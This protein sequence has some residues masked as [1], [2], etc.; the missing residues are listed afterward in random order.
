MNSAPL[1]AEHCLHLL[2]PIGRAGIIVPTSIA[3]D[4][5]NQ[6]FFA[7]L[8]D[9]QSLVSLYDFENRVRVF[10]GI[11]SRI[12]F[13]LL[14]L[15]GTSRPSPQAE[16][17]FFLHHTGQLQDAERHFTLAPTD[18]ALFNPN[19]RT[20]PIF[21]TR[22]DADLA[23]K[24]YRRAGVFW[25]ETQDGE[26]EDN[27]WGI[28]FQLMFMMNTDSHLFRTREQLTS[29]GWR[30]E[31][32]VFVQGDKRYLPLNEAK[33]F[34][35]YDHRF[36]TFDDADDRALRGGHAHNVA[37]NEKADPRAIV[38]PRYWV[39]ETE[40]DKRLENDNRRDSLTR[41]DFIT[42]HSGLSSD[43]RT[44][45]RLSAQSCRSEGRG[46]RGQRCGSVLDVSPAPN[47]Q[48]HC[49]PD[50]NGLDDSANWIGL[51]RGSFQFP[52]LT[53][54]RK[55][56]NSTNERTCIMSFV[57]RAGMSDRAP[58]I[59]PPD[60]E[61]AV[62]L[63]ANFN[64]IVLDFVGRTS[65]GGTDL[66]FFI[67]KQLP[68]LQPEVYLETA[69]SGDTWVELV[70]PRVLELTYTAWDLQ[71][72]AQD[73][74]YDGPPFVWDEERRHRLKCELDAIY[75]HMY[76][77]DQEDLVWILD[78]PEPSQSFS[79]LKRNEERQFGEYRTQRYVLRAYDLLAQG[80]LPNLD[81]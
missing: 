79:G 43:L 13:C 17:A 1:F 73:L 64:S 47:Y 56:T 72:F 63:A 36:A 76:Q 10:P 67:I 46:T 24:L 25:R 61:S 68:V 54:V 18:F 37:T 75:A 62:L 71:P 38:I 15:S 28:R 19:T 78:A 31:R 29:A 70:A 65:V 77:L 30:L 66:S 7:D 9:N 48:R 81:D 34:H 80:Q 14:T 11:D 57:P 26:P 27:P 51:Q 52:W 42:S 5:F 39:P 8:V 40:V 41:N 3:T 6:Y 74:G 16:F 50:G 59:R 23:E 45:L 44:L 60:V 12:K 58:L 35:Q 20:C 55:T 21:R 33:L 4:S 2:S 53:P 69:P 32:N 22:K 49:P